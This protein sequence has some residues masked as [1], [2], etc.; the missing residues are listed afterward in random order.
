[1]S[2]TFIE[3]IEDQELKDTAQDAAIG[4]AHTDAA[5]AQGD[6]DA[7]EG[8]VEAQVKVAVATLAGGAANAFAFAWQN[9]ESVAILI[10][11]IFVDRTAAGGTATAV[12][13]IGTAADA[14]THSDNLIDGLDANATG[15]AD[16]ITDGGTNGKSRQKLDAKDGT[17]DHITG[18]ILT[19]AAEAL[20][21]K[22]YIEYVKVRA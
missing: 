9:P 22:V 14:T 15:L 13:N 3:E 20:A 17:T 18:Q 11:R 12:L 10:Q 21:G 5:T 2:K 7:L 1:M 6:V 19:E 16:N 8:V 4:D